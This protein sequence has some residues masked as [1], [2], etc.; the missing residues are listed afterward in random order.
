MDDG[1]SQVQQADDRDPELEWNHL[2]SSTQS[3]L[4]F[5]ITTHA[6]QRHLPPL[7]QSRRILDAG[8]GPGRYTLFL[9]NL[10]YRVTLLDLSPGLLE[11]ARQHIA[12][13]GLSVQRNVEAVA[14]SIT[15]LSQFPDNHLG[16]RLRLRLRPVDFLTD[17]PLGPGQQA[18]NIL[19]VTDEDDERRSDHKH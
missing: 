12:E 9:A 6:L 16:R 8:G 15:D 3:P 18:Q 11:L 14:G 13:S 4:E 10:G 19:A 17:F 1:L 5:L 7:N 2:D